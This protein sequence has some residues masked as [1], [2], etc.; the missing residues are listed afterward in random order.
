MLR[1]PV[2]PSFN[3]SE[4]NARATAAFMKECNLKE[5]NLLPFHRLGSSKHEQLGSKYA[6]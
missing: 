6:F 4:E 2:I 5:I 3:D 1:M